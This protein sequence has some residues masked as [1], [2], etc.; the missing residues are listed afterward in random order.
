LLLAIKVCHKESRK[1]KRKEREAAIM[2]ML[3]DDDGAGM[4]GPISNIA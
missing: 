4:G 3:A 2:A 1:T